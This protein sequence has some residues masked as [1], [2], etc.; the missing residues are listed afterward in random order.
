M[1]S[2]FWTNTIWFLLL[3]LTSIMAI[4]LLLYK[5]NNL[6]FSI[7]LLFSIIGFSFILEAFLVLGFNAYTYYPKIV[8]IEFLDAVFGNYF[9]QISVSSTALLLAV[10]QRSYLEYCI[11][12]LIYFLLDV[13]F[14]KLGIYKHFWYRS[15]YTFFGFIIFSWIIRKWYEKAKTSNHW[16]IQYI[17]LYFSV[18]SFSTFTI[19]LGQRLL[20]IQLLRGHFFADIAKDNTATGFLYQFIVINYLIILYKSQF[21]WGVK[22]VAFSCL[23]IAQY[24]A[25]R[26][27]FLY[28]YKGLFFF[29]TSMDLIGCY[30][31]IAVFSYLLSSKPFTIQSS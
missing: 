25:Y 24:L 27:G 8:Q 20:G 18:A 28:I 23:F 17:S 11:F 1:G 19:F 2:A 10:Y 9:S 14:L 4:G 16:F 6:K 15:I 30:S 7:A 26:A 3:F 21:H 12:G 13:L 29:V 5:T 31:L 22:T